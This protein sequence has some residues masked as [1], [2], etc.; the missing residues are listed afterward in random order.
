VRTFFNYSP[1][2][3]DFARQFTPR[4]KAQP[5]FLLTQHPQPIIKIANKKKSSHSL[6]LK[7]MVQTNTHK[8]KPL[9]FSHASGLYFTFLF[10][11]SKPQVADLRQLM[12][13]N[14]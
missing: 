11:F 2:V 14:N 9:T 3:I 8:K 4:N 6:I 12:K 10:Q 5:T 13:I 7:I 1:E